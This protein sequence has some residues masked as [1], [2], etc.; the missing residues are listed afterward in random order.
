VDERA[1]R[2]P[3]R[4]NLIGDH[5]DYNDGF[6]LPVAIQLECVVRSTPNDE[7]LVLIRSRELAGAVELAADGS[8]APQSVQPAWGQYAAG[9]LSSLAARGRRP[10]GMDAAVSSTVPVGSGLSSSAAFEVS[11]A[12]ALCDV[13]DLS[14]TQVDLAQA[15]QAADHAIGVPA[16]IM[17]QL[18]SIAGRRGCALLIDCRSLEVRPIPLPG[19]L[20]TIVIHSGV[21]RVLA[22]SDYAARRAACAAA[23]R[24]LGVP[25]LRDALPEDVAD[26]PLARHVVSENARVL[27]AADALARGDAETLGR[28]MGESHA[29]LRDDFRVSTPELDALVGALVDEGAVG[30]RLTGAGFG[31]CVVALAS[32]AE[33]ETIAAAASE[34]YRAQ[35]GNEPVVT[36]CHAVDG[37]GRLQTKGET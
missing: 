23:A 22:A 7:G 28:L 11:L 14:L 17:D 16:G 30:A 36:L 31:G 5:T 10:V 6:V 33:A 13:A 15:C 32:E 18:T 26:D 3:G 27:A 20:R 25:A 1:F 24:R 9:L 2:A 12:L 19:D 37:A 35:T 21:P 29:S 4:V 34:R 8:A